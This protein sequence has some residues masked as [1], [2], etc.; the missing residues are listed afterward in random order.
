MKKILL[1]LSVAL[2]SFIFFLPTLI[3]ASEEYF[4]IYLVKI[5]SSSIALA[6]LSLI[7]LYSAFKTKY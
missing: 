2:A 5:I 3:M 1:G 6:T 7:C 4:E